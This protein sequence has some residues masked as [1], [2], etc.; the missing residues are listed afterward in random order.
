MGEILNRRTRHEKAEENPVLDDGHPPPLDPLIVVR[1]GPHQIL[2]GTARLSGI[3]V[4]REGLGQ[5]LLP[6]FL[7]KGLALVLALLA[8]PLN[9]VPENFVEQDAAGAARQNSRTRVGSHHRGVAQGVQVGDHV[10]HQGEDLLVA[11]QALWGKGREGFVAR[12]FHAVVGLGEGVDEQAVEHLRGLDLAALAVDVLASRDIGPKAGPSFVDVA[13]LGEGGR[14]LLELGLPC[15]AGNVKGGGGFHIALDRLFGEIVRLV[16]LFH[17]DLDV[18]LDR[19]QLFDGAL[20]FLVGVVPEHTADGVW[21][22]LNGNFDHGIAVGEI[23][24][25]AAHLMRIVEGVVS[26]AQVDVEL[27]ATRFI[28]ISQRTEGSPDPDPLRLRDFVAEVVGRDW[29]LLEH[30]EGAGQF[31]LHGL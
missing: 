30:T 2:A 1:V 9:A 23:A 8:V 28:T 15:G 29:L 20:V 22:V 19:S 27:A 10:F 13:V 11:G 18:G 24:R 12:Q 4:H 6:Y 5:D 17:L 7:L 16:F 26:H 31:L 14:V 3:E 21:I 25:A